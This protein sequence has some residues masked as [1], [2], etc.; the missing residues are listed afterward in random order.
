MVRPTNPWGRKVPNLKGKNLTL[1]QKTYLAYLVNDRGV[2]PSKLSRELGISKSVIQKYAEVT[3]K[4]GKRQNRRMFRLF[5]VLPF[6]ND[7]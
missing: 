5:S 6:C 4:G 2:S 3:L 1:V 7:T